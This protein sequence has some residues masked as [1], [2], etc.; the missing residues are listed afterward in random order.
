MKTYGLAYIN[1]EHKVIFSDQKEQ[2]FF[3]MKDCDKQEYKEIAK[4][5]LVHGIAISN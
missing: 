1:N 4:P 3:V 2:R 5:T